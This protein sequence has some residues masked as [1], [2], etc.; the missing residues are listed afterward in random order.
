M[1]SEHITFVQVVDRCS[2]IIVEKVWSSQCSHT[3][4]LTS[5][6]HPHK[7][8][9]LIGSSR[10]L[11]HC[12][13][14]S[15]ADADWTPSIDVCRLLGCSESSTNIFKRLM[16]LSLK[17]GGLTTLVAHFF[18]FRTLAIN[19]RVLSKNPAPTLFLFFPLKIFELFKIMQKASSRPLFFL[20]NLFRML[21]LL[22]SFFKTMQDAS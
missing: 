5:V 15:T 16:K 18:T 2:L 13:T 20:K 22:L 6:D 9:G 4:Y 11:V 21:H 1:C 19:P 3:V 17:F 14:L 8:F 12:R 10:M 7:A